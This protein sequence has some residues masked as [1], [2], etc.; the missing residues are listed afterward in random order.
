MVG[1]Y[2][3]KSIIMRCPKKRQT[4]MFSA[5]ISSDTPTSGSIII[6]ESTTGAE[7]VCAYTS[8]TGAVFTLSGTTANAYDGSDTA[9]VPFI[10]EQASG[11][12]VTETTTIYTSDKYVVCRV[13]VA[14]IKPFETVGTYGSTGYSAAAIRT[15]DP[16]YT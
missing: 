13:R 5:T 9:Y 10:Y 2:Y 3:V 6:V 7:E 11:T 8:Y 16:V 4:L 14:G 1:K 12:S 15:T